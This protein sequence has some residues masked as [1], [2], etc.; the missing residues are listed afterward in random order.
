MR[1][2]ATAED[3]QRV[4]AVQAHESFRRV[5][6]QSCAEFTVALLESKEICARSESAG[7]IRLP[8]A[9]GVFTPESL[10]D[11]KSEARRPVLDRLLAVPGTLN[12]GFEVGIAGD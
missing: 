10:F 1:I 12:T 11:V 7:A 8:V 4:S 2:D 9:S 6:G 5:V 3:G